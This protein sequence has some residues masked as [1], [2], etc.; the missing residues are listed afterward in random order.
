M[1][2]TAADQLA[3]GVVDEVVPEPPEGAHQDPEQT[4]RV[5][6]EVARA[7]PGAAGRT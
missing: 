7:A 2:L 4:A 5:L 6:R 3:L 1:R